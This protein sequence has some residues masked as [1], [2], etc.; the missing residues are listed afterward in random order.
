MAGA[1]VLRGGA[2]GSLRA[3]RGQEHARKPRRTFRW[4]VALEAVKVMPGWKRQS[5]AS[6]LWLIRERGNR[7]K[8]L[9][10]V[11]TLPWRWYRIFVWGRGSHGRHT[12]RGGM[13]LVR[14]GRNIGSRGLWPKLHLCLPC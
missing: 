8:L 3:C 4:A 14:H 5:N 6:F 12:C 10:G 11:L 2:R 13:R 7:R 9:D 1:P